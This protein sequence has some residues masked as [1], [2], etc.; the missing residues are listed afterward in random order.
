MLD[1]IKN[2]RSIRTY[3][4]T[5]VEE[6]KIIDIIKAGM[7]SPSS[8]NSKPWEFVIIDDKEVLLELSKVQHRAKHIKDAPICIAILGNRERFLKPGKWMQDLGACTQN[9]LL[10]ITNQDLASCWV[11]VFPKKKVV[12]KTVNALNLPENLVPYALIPIGYSDEK[13]KFEDRFDINLI[14]K[15]KF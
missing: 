8:K 12:D 2:R 3:R 7:Q 4:D 5:L 13:N 10:E 14:H 15:N 1:A 11:G 9:I 6:E